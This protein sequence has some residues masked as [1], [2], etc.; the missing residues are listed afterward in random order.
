MRYE[1]LK[2]DVDGNGIALITW[3]MPNHSMN[4]L[5]ES[6]IRE[7][8]DAISRV[9]DDADI[10]GA[11]ITS[12]KK[13]FIAGADL[14]MLEG[15]SKR[16]LRDNTPATA[17]ALFEKLMGFQMSLR[18]LE[19]CGKP[20]AS[21]VPGAALG[22]GLEVVLATHRR[23]VG[24]NSRAQLGLPEC[25]V[26]LMPGAGGTQRLVRL[27]GAMAAAPIIMEGRS[28]SPAEAKK[29]GVIHE[30]IPMGQEVVTAKAWVRQHIQEGDSVSKRRALGEKVEASF[31]Q[32]WDKKGFQVPGGAP[33]TPQG[34]PIFMGASAM[35]RKNTYDLYEAQKAILAAVYEGLQVPFDTALAIEVRY[36]TKLIRGAQARNMIRSLFIN[37][38]AL[39]KGAR[40]PRDLPDMSVKKLGVLGGG[41]FMGAGIAN[42]SAA[43]GID[44]VVLDVD[45]ASANKARAHAERQLEGRV[46]KGRISQETAEAILARISTTSDYKR[47]ED[48]D[49]VVEAVFESL[50]IKKLVTQTAEQYLKP[51]AI[52]ASNTSTIPITQLAKNS[53]RSN[54]YIGVHFFS[55]VEKMP[56][57]EIITGA[58]TGDEAL[59]KALDYARQL[60]KIPIVVNDARF[61]YAN[62]CVIKY[63]EES[64]HM[65][66]EG[67]KAALIENAARM[68]G[69][70]VGPLSLNDET[71]LDL[72]QK[73]RHT[74]RAALGDDYDEHPAESRLDKMVDEMG[75]LGR[76]SRKGFYDYPEEGKKRIWPGLQDL[77]P[78]A[79]EQPDVEEV[80][81]RLI[82]IQAIEAVHALAEHV[83][84]DVREADIGAIFGWGFAPWTGGPISYIDTRG[85]EQVVADC[86]ELAQE[87]GQRFKAPDLLR[88]VAGSGHTFYGRFDPTAKRRAA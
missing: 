28:V 13:D 74:T 27:V 41:G 49:L 1:N 73:I 3:D 36:F 38:Q 34:F 43:S 30:I 54:R 59:A 51:S 85:P 23:V 72:G 82:T 55:P 77:F 66:A 53:K 60:R 6:S 39:E 83:V 24:D 11:V 14:N 33:Q 50:E 37:K 70:P 25:K 10:K 67:V 76:K 32:P 26:G 40:R 64:H 7:Y 12:A 20:I 52:F 17:Q 15:M 44:V 18:K 5:T 19:Y 58:D 9:V 88:E 84:T 47:L 65:L 69:M 79:A 56:L 62:R 45:E 61:F 71:A 68:I 57:V 87:F 2:F 81:L 48:C 35:L 4:V 78:L 22:G 8:R 75:R 31:D 21:A 86:D 63:I 80:K 46:A 29:L 42:V 16:A